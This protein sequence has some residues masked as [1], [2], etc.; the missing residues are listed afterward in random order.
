MFSIS[1][2]SL[3]GMGPYKTQFADYTDND[4]VH[5]AFLTHRPK[6][7]RVETPSNPIL[8]IIDIRTMLTNAGKC[9]DAE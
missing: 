1:L 2:T 3:S 9:V 6:I 8:H 4:A 7:I 5:R